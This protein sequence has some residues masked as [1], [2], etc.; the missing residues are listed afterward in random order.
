MRPLWHALLFICLAFAS[1]ADHVPDTSSLNP[2]VRYQF[3]AAQKRYADVYKIAALLDRYIAATGDVPDLSPDADDTL[4]DVAVLGQVRA[5][6]QIFDHGTPFGFSL[7]K[8]RARPLIEELEHGLG[9]DIILP[10]DPQK[11]GVTFHPVY[12]V[13]LKPAR[14]GASGH[15]VVL[16]SFAQSVRHSTRVGDDVHLLG[17]TNNIDAEFMIPLKAVSS[18]SSDEITHI[19]SVGQDAD[20][21]FGKLVDIFVE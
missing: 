14:N 8:F 5:V 11:V 19:L 6:N 4:Y 1:H 9:Q 16:G 15:Y 18:L 10:I 2:L 17:L 21:I 3:D 20:E 7:R 12:F 13:F